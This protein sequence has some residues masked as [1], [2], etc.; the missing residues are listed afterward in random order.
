MSPE[1]RKAMHA[2]LDQAINLEAHVLLTVHAEYNEDNIPLTN[3]LNNTADAAPSA[4]TVQASESVTGRRYQILTTDPSSS[5]EIALFT[6]VSN[7]SRNG[8]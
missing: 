5:A 1:H 2:L 4:Y 3:L 7:R 6:N 8:D